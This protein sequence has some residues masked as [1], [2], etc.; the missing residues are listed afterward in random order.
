LSRHKLSFHPYL[1][2]NDTTTVLVLKRIT[3]EDTAASVIELIARKEAVHPMKS[4]TDLRRRLGPGRRVFSLFH[5]FLPGKP[6]AFVHAALEN[7][8]PS[9]MSQV[10]QQ[11]AAKEHPKVATFY[12]ITN[13]AP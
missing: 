9:A 7:E 1:L 13:A 5:P 6:L 4:L 2:V 3:Y 10:M 8:I 12:S 11:V